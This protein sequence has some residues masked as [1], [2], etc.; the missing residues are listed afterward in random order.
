[1][2]G[3]APA[4]RLKK[5]AVEGPHMLTSQIQG[6]AHKLEKGATARKR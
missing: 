3:N 5:E 1:M 2:N 6:L 4:G